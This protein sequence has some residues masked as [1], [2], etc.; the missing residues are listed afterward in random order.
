MYIFIIPEGDIPDEETWFSLVNSYSSFRKEV[1]K[2]EE[3][4]ANHDGNIKQSK[5][6]KGIRERKDLRRKS[7]KQITLGLSD[8]E[9]WN[10]WNRCERYDS[11]KRVLTTISSDNISPKY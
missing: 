9:T 1:I 6:R 11:K 2:G 5:N 8:K 4:N 3:A 10:V 7:Y